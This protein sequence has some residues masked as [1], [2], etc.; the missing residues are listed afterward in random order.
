[1]TSTGVTLDSP[2]RRDPFTLVTNHAD[3]YTNGHPPSPDS[4]S[5]PDTPKPQIPPAYDLP[6]ISLRAFSLGL[7]LG[8]STLVAVLLA[9][10]NQP[11]WRLPFF[12]STLSLFHFLEYQVTA[13]YNPSAATVSAFLLTSNGKA[14]NVAHGLA[15][16]ECSL[17][18]LLIPSATK[19]ILQLTLIPVDDGTLSTLHNLRL[20]LG[21]GMLGIGQVTRT[22]AMVHAG[23]NFNH[24]V[25]MRKRHGHFLVTD[26]IYAWL[27]HPS[28]FGFFWWG[29]GTQVILGNAFCLAGYTVVLRRFFRH[30]IREEEKL[31]VSFFGND[32]K[33]YR[34][35][36]KTGLPF[37]P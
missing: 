19:R 33:E 30:R 24:T 22:M 20:A 17:R 36:V 10:S 14:Y 34:K 31:L 32:Y 8:I 23:S 9:I 13:A 4:L 3:S 25:Q 29:L 16:L 26:G 11:L 21:F 6:A 12:L 18:L 1:M 37:C 2:N 5:S 35:K 15:F 28:Y 27:R 7:V